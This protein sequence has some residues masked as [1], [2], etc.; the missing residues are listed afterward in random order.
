M[1]TWI[2][3]ALGL[4]TVKVLIQWPMFREIESDLNVPILV[5]DAI[6]TMFVLLF[7]YYQMT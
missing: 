4:L 6:S 5:V 7:M 1:H 2:A 3:T